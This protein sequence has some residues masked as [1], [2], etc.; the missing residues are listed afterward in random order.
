MRASLEKN[1][2]ENIVPFWYPQSIDRVDGGYLSITTLQVTGRVRRQELSGAGAHAMVLRPAPQQPVPICQ[3]RGRRGP[4]VRVSRTLLLG[5]S[6]GRI[7]L[8]RRLHGAPIDC[9]KHLYGQAFAL[10]ALS[11]Y[12]IAAGDERAARRAEELF[13]LVERHARDRSHGGYR[14]F[15]HRDWSAPG[16]HEIGYLASRQG[17]R[18]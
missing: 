7:P 4:W 6:V 15:L 8:A 14:E 9:D 16:P 18:R 11:E 17:S 3:L 13:D 5:R 12:A 10:Y 1:L 2:T